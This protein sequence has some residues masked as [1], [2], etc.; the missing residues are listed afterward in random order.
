[1]IHGWMDEN[2]INNYTYVPSFLFI[3]FKH[4]N[5][6]KQSSKQECKIFCNFLLLTKWFLMTDSED[7]A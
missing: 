1:M 4:A 2:E 3:Y 6:F 7:K 5:W